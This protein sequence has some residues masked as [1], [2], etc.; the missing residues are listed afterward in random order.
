MS[1]ARG[2]SSDVSLEENPAGGSWKVHV[3]SHTLNLL[4]MSSRVLLT[5]ASTS[6]HCSTI[7]RGRKAVSSSSASSADQPAHPSLSGSFS[8]DQSSRGLSLRWRHLPAE[9]HRRISEWKPSLHRGVEPRLETL[10]LT[11][12][13]DADGDADERLPRTCTFA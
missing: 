10:G 6:S 7:C 12:E 1:A 4:Q 2:S 13:D 8:S 11:D 3:G 5:P 9:N